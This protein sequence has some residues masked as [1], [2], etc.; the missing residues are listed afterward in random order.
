M[1][2]RVP[3]SY[4]DLPNAPINQ[5]LFLI[6]Y[7]I[8]VL[9][10]VINRSAKHTKTLF[11]AFNNLI[12]NTNLIEKIQS[13]FRGFLVCI[14]GK[15][16]TGQIFQS[17]HREHDTEFINH[18]TC[19]TNMVGVHMRHKNLTDRLALECL[20]ENIFPN[21]FGKVI[22]QSCINNDPRVTIFQQPNIYMIQCLK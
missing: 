1:L 8:E 17:R 12:R 15:H 10:Q 4:N 21:F 16:T 3:I 6:T 7:T 9:R 5:Y 11:I 18:P 14:S 22:I 13:F 20:I 19:Q 2:R